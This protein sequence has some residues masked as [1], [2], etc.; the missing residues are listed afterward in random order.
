MVRVVCVALL[1]VAMLVGSASAECAWVL[2]TETEALSRSRA[3]NWTSVSFDRNVYRTREACEVARVQW[4]ERQGQIA[5]DLGIRV[6][7][8]GD[9]NSDISNDKDQY[10]IIDLLLRKVTRVT[11][12][13]GPESLRDVVVEQ[14]TCLPDTLDPRGRG[15]ADR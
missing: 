11:R 1:V 4:M 10:M 12:E 8:R 6:F 2:W 3:G 9:G 13:Q 15:A 14:F 5:R 7:R